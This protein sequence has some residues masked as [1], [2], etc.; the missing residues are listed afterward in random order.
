MFSRN[1]VALITQ[2]TKDLA[3]AIDADVEVAGPMTVVR[4]GKVISR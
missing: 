1:L 2:L 4:D 3:F